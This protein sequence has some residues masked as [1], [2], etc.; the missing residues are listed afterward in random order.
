MI[1]LQKFIANVEE[2]HF[3]RIKHTKAFPENAVKYVFDANSIDLKDMDRVSFKWD[4]WKS[5]LEKCKD[6]II[7]AWVFIS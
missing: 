4:P 1:I 7:K 3:N 6:K 5:L 2:V